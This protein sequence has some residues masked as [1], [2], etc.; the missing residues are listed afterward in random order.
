MDKKSV[1]KAI[2]TIKDPMVRAYL[3]NA[4]QEQAENG[5]L[6]K[7]LEIACDEETKFG[8]C[9]DEEDDSDG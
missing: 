6:K 7:A 1:W 8:G 2:G 9:C 5:T 3:E 4:V